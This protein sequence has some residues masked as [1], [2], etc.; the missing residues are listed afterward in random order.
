M[1]ILFIPWDSIGRKDLEEAFDQEGHILIHSSIFQEKKTYNDLPEVEE[2]LDAILKEEAPD[3]V[4]TVNYYPMISDFCERHRIRY[5]S[6]VYD[7]PFRRIYSKTVVNP[8]NTIYV[9]DSQLYQEFHEAGI[10]TVRYLPMAANAGRLDRI[11]AGPK[12][13]DVSFVGSLYLE[14]H[15]PFTKMSEFL[16]DYSKGY[17]D[18]LV[19]VQLKLQGCDLIPDSLGPV[20]EDMRKAYPM[21]REPGSIEPEENYYAQHIIN[22]WVTTVERVDLLDAVAQKYGVDFF[23][24]YQG[25]HLE[26]LKNHGPADYM[27]EMPRI[28]K[29]SKINLNISRRG[30]KGGV[31]LRAF[32]IMGSG[33]FLLSNFQPDFLDMFIPGEDFV[34]YESKEDMLDKIGYYLCHEEEREAIARNGHDKVAAA[35]TYRHRIREMLRD[36]T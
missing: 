24:Y 7:S 16:S 13:Y 25:F 18:A 36:I 2:R 20:M 12:I 26:G 22:R 21:V 4:F 3:L 15:Q 33:G 14:T 28:F 29:G 5:V 32:D 27:T 6:W 10:E 31:P 19:T 1:K 8:C 35:H 30:M 34:Y 23:T 11:A 17:L 9:F